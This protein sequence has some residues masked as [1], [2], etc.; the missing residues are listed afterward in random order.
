M[1][2]TSGVFCPPVLPPPEDRL[3][4]GIADSCLFLRCAGH[5]VLP[6]EVASQ[7]RLSIVAHHLIY[8]QVSCNATLPCKQNLCYKVGNLFDERYKTSSQRCC[9]FVVVG[10]QCMHTLVYVD[11]RMIDRQTDRQSAGRQND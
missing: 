9:N 8:L 2:V 3:I 10:L 6:L 4:N 5:R 1:K 11:R 7:E